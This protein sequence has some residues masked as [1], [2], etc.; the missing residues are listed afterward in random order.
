MLNWKT[1]KVLPYV[2]LAVF[3]LIP[4]FAVADDVTDSINEGLEYYQKGDHGSAVESLNFAVQLIQQMKGAGLEAF[5]PEPLDGWTAEPAN[6][7]ATG[8][9]M[10]GGSVSANREY[11]KGSSSVDIQIITDSP[12]LQGVMMMFSNPMF[13]AS[14]GG[15]LEKINGEK[16]I[17]KYDAGSRDGEVQLVIANRFYIVVNGNDVNKDD[18]INY[19][20]GIDFKKLATLP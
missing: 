12:M 2:F 6:S 5:L 10:M 8:A 18:L 16:G 20:Q 13:A 14:S 7:Q 15:K 3:L 19:A 1:G 4:A 9:A 17:V 11:S